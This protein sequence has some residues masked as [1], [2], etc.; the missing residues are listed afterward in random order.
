MLSRFRPVTIRQRVQ[1]VLALIAYLMVMG[2]VPAGHMAAPLAGGTPFHLCPSDARSA[3]LLQ[4]LAPPVTDDELPV[5]H[6]LHHGNHH[7]DFG[8]PFSGESHD[9]HVA[10]TTDSHGGVHAHHSA[11][12]QSDSHS[13]AQCPLGSASAAKLLVSNDIVG[14]GLDSVGGD[15]FGDHQQRLPQTQ[16]WLRPRPRSPPV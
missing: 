10:G 4:A 14:D 9:G 8:D 11:D 2:V 13:D 5:Q 6:H 3:L 16:R 7:A 15:L 1:A 12:N